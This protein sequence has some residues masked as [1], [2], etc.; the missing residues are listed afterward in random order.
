MPGGFTAGTFFGGA[1]GGASAGAFPVATATGSGAFAFAGSTA[2][3]GARG[4]AEPLDFGGPAFAQSGVAAT[5]CSSRPGSAPGSG[6]GG[7]GGSLGVYGTGCQE[8]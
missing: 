2:L 8:P 7:T 4:K 3:G 5:N 1:A 6:L